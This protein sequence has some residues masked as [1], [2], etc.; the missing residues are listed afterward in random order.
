MKQLEIVFGPGTGLY[1]LCEHRRVC[2]S[3][4]ERNKETETERDKQREITFD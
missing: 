3:G 4:S 1:N 2:V